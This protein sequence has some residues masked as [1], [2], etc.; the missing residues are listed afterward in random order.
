MKRTRAILGVALAGALLG[1]S[2]APSEY[3]PCV[4]ASAGGVCDPDGPD[5]CSFCGDGED[6][7]RCETYTCRDGVWGYE[8]VLLTVDCSP[9]PERDRDAISD[10]E[11]S[12]TSQDG[13]VSDGGPLADSAHEPTPA[14]PPFYLG[15]DRPATYYMPFD[16]DGQ[17][18]IPLLL[19][20]HGFGHFGQGLD[21]YFGLSALTKTMGMMLVTPDGT[22]NPDDNQFWSATDACCNYYGSGVDDV[23]YLSGL[24]EEALMHFAVD[25]RRVYLIGHSNG[26]FMASRLAC[27]RSDLIAGFVNVA[28]ATWFDPADCGDPEPV[29]MLH[30]HGDWDT[31]IPYGGVTPHVAQL[32]DE[33]VVVDTCL[34]GTCADEYDACL[35]D[36]ACGAYY[37]CLGSC[38]TSPEAM[39]CYGEC[40]DDAPDEARALWMPTFTC[41]LGAGCYVSDPT[42]SWAGYPGAVEIAERWAERNGCA[43]TTTEAAALDLI[44]EVAG[45]ETIPTPYD[46]CPEGLQTELWTILRGSHSPAFTSAW[47]PA[48]VSWLLDQRKPAEP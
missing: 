17:T 21:V 23:A 45:V 47:G 36:A 10:V 29:A 28:G 25:P 42:L 9:E 16:Y 30:V 40:W 41:G 7:G 27:E 33:P 8:L 39:A 43:P 35:A 11:P 12:D 4:E 18:P 2:D 6:C 19:S 15:G 38:S 3:Q 34:S 20:L 14:P 26:G 22:V 24:I 37:G 48:L 5:Q 1:C 32:G 31:T 46:G 44:Q 13:A